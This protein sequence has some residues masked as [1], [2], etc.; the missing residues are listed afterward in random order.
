MNFDIYASD[1]WVS[2]HAFITYSEK[3]S[4][5][6]EFVCVDISKKTVTPLKA[7]NQIFD[8]HNTFETYDFP[9][10]PETSISPD[11]KWLLEGNYY[12]GVSGTNCPTESDPV[13]RTIYILST[14][15]SHKI[16][17]I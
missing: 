7:L 17:D 11:G 5:K 2:D 16:T 10:S 13:R 15:G 4:V 8:P 14:D 9:A 3:N 6:A 12:K 1:Y